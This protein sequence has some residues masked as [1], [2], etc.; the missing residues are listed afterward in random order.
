MPVSRSGWGTAR[1]RVSRP[2][3]IVM[4]ARVRACV[5]HVFVQCRRNTLHPARADS[6]RTSVSSSHHAYLLTHHLLTPP[7]PNP[8]GPGPGSAVAQAAGAAGG[9]RSARRT[10]AAHAG[11]EGAGGLAGG[12]RGVMAPADWGWSWLESGFS[13]QAPQLW[14][15]CHSAMSA[16]PSSSSPPPYHLRLLICS[17]AASSPAP[18]P[19]P[20]PLSRSCASRAL[21]PPPPRR[22]CAWRCVRAPSA[23][24]AAPLCSAPPRP[25]RTDSRSCS[26]WQGC[27]Q[28]VRARGRRES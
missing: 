19:L 3:D 27:R 13:P 12:L 17:P 10:Q 4:R 2:P 28:R 21:P 20:P 5:S 8:T 16:C 26:G 6:H 18:P 23:T 9:G 7:P 24:A 11:G 25:R 1:G 22:P 14:A 15:P